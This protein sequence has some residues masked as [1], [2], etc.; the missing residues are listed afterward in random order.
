[1]TM[2]ER[3]QHLLVYQVLIRAGTVRHS[4]HDVV[5]Y[6][7]AWVWHDTRGHHFFFF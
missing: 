3:A 6:G 7:M 2:L 4:M 5:W 1:M